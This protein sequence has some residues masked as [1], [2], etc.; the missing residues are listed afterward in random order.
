MNPKHFPLFFSKRMVWITAFYF[1]SII[2]F[3]RIYSNIYISSR[4][5]MGVKLYLFLHFSD[6]KSFSVVFVYLIFISE[7]NLYFCLQ[8]SLQH[9]YSSINSRCLF[10]SMFHVISVVKSNIMWGEKV[11]HCLQS[12]N[13]FNAASSLNLYFLLC[14]RWTFISFARQPQLMRFWKNKYCLIPICKRNSSTSDIERLSVLSLK[15]QQ[16]KHVSHRRIFRFFFK[17]TYPPQRHRSQYGHNVYTFS[18]V[19]TPFITFP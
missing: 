11:K 2:I 10:I 9:S 15:V 6:L 19:E 14:W 5:G 4:E 16:S 3:G 7:F 12:T 18:Q 13:E 8:H 17:A 1:C